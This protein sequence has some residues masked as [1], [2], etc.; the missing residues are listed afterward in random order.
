MLNA[1]TAVASVPEM[2]LAAAAEVGVEFGVVVASGID[3]HL[4]PAVMALVEQQGGKGM[5]RN[6]T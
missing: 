2:A 1:A 6:H 3:D 4:K 5:L